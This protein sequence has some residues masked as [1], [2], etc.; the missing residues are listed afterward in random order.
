MSNTKEICSVLVEQIKTKHGEVCRLV[1]DT[2]ERASQAVTEAVDCG[3]LIQDLK[4]F[5]KSDF[6][7]FWAQ[8]WEVPYGVAATYLR[9]YRQYHDRGRVDVTAE[10]LKAIGAID[11]RP[12]KNPQLISNEE[13]SWGTVLSKSWDSLVV[14]QKRQPIAHWPEDRRAAL[15]AEL[16]PFY[17]LYVELES[18][19]AKV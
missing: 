18:N 1:G 13:A 7:Q 17:E 12:H 11:G 8:M 5:H 4:S 10:S 19:Q 9:L 15:R 16:R 14:I 2:K 3:R 6:R